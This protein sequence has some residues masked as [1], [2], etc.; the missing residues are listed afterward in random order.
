MSLCWNWNRRA[1]GE[2]LV[3]LLGTFAAMTFYSVPAAGQIPDVPGWEL[4][5]HDEFDGTSL[6]NANWTALNRENSYN[7]EL[8]YYRPEQ[9][10]VANGNLQITATNQPLSTKLYRSGLITSRAIYGP[11]RFEARMDLPTS[12]GMWPAFWL[13]A[14]QVSWPQGG[15]IDI[16]ENQGH[17]P[18][19]VASAYHWQDSAGVHQQV[20]QSRNYSGNPADNYHSSFHT[21]AVEWD[22]TQLRFFV[23]GVLY[24]THTETASTPIVETAKN[25]IINVAVGGD[26]VGRPD[27]TT[28][29]PQTMLVDYVRVWHR[30]KGLQGD[31]DGD[32][33]VSAS[34]YTVWRDTFGRAG[35]GLA[36]DGS[37][38]GSV[39][40]S[41]YAVWKSNFGSEGGSAALES[42]SRALPEPGFLWIAGGGAAGCETV[43]RRMRRR[44]WALNL[45]TGLILRP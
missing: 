43:I 44:N 27:G 17:R 29:F 15:E 18:T 33:S 40:L 26:Y 1:I 14:N 5:W 42:D 39:D 4:F 30:Q 10:T 20:S 34:D 35:I 22:E 8:Q 28:V 38:N 6:N 25:I 45:R 32:G 21:Y 2:V 11:G 37:G 31:Y 13:N 9:V 36:A 24:H 12:R 7:N 16:M 19:R 41:D 23:D 3:G